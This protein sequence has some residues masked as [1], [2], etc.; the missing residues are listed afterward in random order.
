MDLPASLSQ[1]TAAIEQETS[2][3]LLQ[4]IRQFIEELQRRHI[5]QR[6]LQPGDTVPNF[7]LKNQHQRT[8]SLYDQLNEGPVVL[9][10]YRGGWCP[11]CNLEL[12]AWQ[13]E[14]PEVTFS[15]AQLLAVTPENISHIIHTVRKNALDFPV[16]HDVNSEVA[17]AFGLSATLSN[18]IQAFYRSLGLN[19]SMRN[20]DMKVRLPLPA[21]YVIGT[22]FTV[23]YA[24]VDEDY[25]NRAP[26]PEILRLLPLL[27]PEKIYAYG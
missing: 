22:D 15:G 4:V 23:Q 20:A 17:S 3:R 8:V 2:P 26:L 5:V 21:T 27:K 10:F 25:R 11:Y 19:L 13:H 7:S 18:H 9:K 1:L 12:K 14:L 24:F 16:L 6:S